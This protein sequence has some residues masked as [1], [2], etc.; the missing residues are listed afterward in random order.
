MVEI[1]KCYN[2]SKK[3]GYMFSACFALT[4]HK[5]IKNH[6]DWVS[7][8]KPSLNLYNWAGIEYPASINKNNH[9]LFEN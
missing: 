8:I 4:H 6:P 3:Y 2:K 5:D 9:T 7:N 1:E